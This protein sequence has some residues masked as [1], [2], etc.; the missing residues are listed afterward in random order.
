M[1]DTGIAYQTVIEDRIADLWTRREW[2]RSHLGWIIQQRVEDM[3]ELRLLVRL[4]RKA[5]RLAAL[6]QEQTDNLAKQRAQS[7]AYRAH[8]APWTPGELM[9]AYGV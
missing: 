9:E 8:N 1:N 4:A 2:Y 5:R 3:A 6:S 7:N